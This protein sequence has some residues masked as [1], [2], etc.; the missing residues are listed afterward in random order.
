M[1]LSVFF[2][3]KYT[4]INIKLDYFDFISIDNVNPTKKEI[5]ILIFFLYGHCLFENISRLVLKHYLNAN[6]NN[7]YKEKKMRTILLTLDDILDL[8]SSVTGLLLIFVLQKWTSI[9]YIL[10]VIIYIGIIAR[11]C[12]VIY[13]HFYYNNLSIVNKVSAIKK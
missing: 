10:S 8:I 2:I 3:N 5:C 6:L 12:S 9:N 13:A 1:A 4:I 11:T 7:E